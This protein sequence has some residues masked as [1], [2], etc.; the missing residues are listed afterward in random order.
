MQQQFSEWYNMHRVLPSLKTLLKAEA[1]ATYLNNNWYYTCG[2]RTAVAMAAK[3]RIISI[4][5]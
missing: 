2:R 5:W 3:N 1:Y 4:T